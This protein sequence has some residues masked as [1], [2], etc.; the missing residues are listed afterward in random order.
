[1]IME[2]RKNY[3]WLACAHFLLSS[4]LAGCASAQTVSTQDLSKDEAVLAE[5]QKRVDARRA[6]L[7]LANKGTSKLQA[8]DVCIKRLEESPK[9]IVVGFFAYDRGCGL[10]GAFVDSRYFEKMDAALSKNALDA[11]GWESANQSR[12]EQLAKLWIEKGLLA[13]FTVLYTKEKDLEDRGFHPPQAVSNENGEIKVTL[14]IRL[15]SGMRPERGYQHLEYRFARDG[16]LS[17]SSV[18]ESLSL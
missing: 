8:H 12:R 4:L 17:G 13:F 2:F 16:N 1:M 14:W 11:L 18:L 9:I 5:M 3:L 10:D 7:G 6:K 15:P